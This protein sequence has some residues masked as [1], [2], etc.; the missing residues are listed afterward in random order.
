MAQIT[1]V[2]LGHIG[3][4]FALALKAAGVKATLV[5]HD[6]DHEQAK[7]IR[8]MGGLD[9]IDWNLISACEGADVLILATP[10]AGI[11]QTMEVT[12]QYLKPGCVV[13]DTASLKAPVLQWADEFLPDTVSFVG[14]NPITGPGGGEE[15]RADLFQGITYCLTPHIRSAAS[16][17]DLISN[18]V[19]A[20]G[21][22]PY[23]MDPAEHDG[24]LAAVEQ[25]PFIL[26]AALLRTATHTPV[27]R[28]LRR[29]AGEAFATGTSFSSPLAETYRDACLNNATNIVRWVDAFRDELDTLRELIL[30]ADEEKLGQVFAE[31]LADRR[32]WE[33]DARRGRWEEVPSQ[34][35]EV[36]TGM[37][38]LAQLLGL[39]GRRRRREEE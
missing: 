13:T 9:K 34:M 27:W 23:F 10:L 25:L 28:E 36:P 12:A 24:L 33:Q 30:T 11:R 16:A 26:A 1:I 32:Q 5:G 31:A 4:S 29:L 15:I 17:V 3:G 19:R 22:Q 14:G 20:I 2:G 35:G 37:D 8:K 38:M 18:L 6:R 39:G 7:R 21:A